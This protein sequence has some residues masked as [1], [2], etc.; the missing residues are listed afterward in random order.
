MLSLVSVS[1]FLLAQ[2]VLS[3]ATDFYFDQPQEPSP[4]ERGFYWATRYTDI[5]GTFNFMPDNYFM[6]AEI[7]RSGE[8]ITMADICGQQNAGC[9]P[10]TKPE[11][12]I[13]KSAILL[14]TRRNILCSLHYQ[15]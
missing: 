10:L 15:I 3:P 7:K 5:H 13:G 8:A 1:V 11:N 9:P 4:D 12:I 2:V 6:N 14:C